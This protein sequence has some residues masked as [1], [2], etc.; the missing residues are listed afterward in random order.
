MPDALLKSPFDGG[1]VNLPAMLVILFISFLL[2]LGIKASSRFNIAM[3]LIKLAVIG[4]FIAI[5]AVNINTTYWQPFMPF[6]W[7]GVMSGAA[8]VFFAYIGFDAVSTTAEEVINPQRN[9]PIGIIVSLVICTLLYIIVSG[10][11]T[12]T[13]PYTHLN[14]ASPIS[15][16]LSH[17]GHNVAASLI[18]IGA[19]SGL[20]T[21]ILVL[22]YALTRVFFAMSRD[23]LLPSFFA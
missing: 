13:V 23:K 15:A 16:A 12:G 8:I 4:L 19:I 10:L 14:V 3:V 17:L 6:G 7:H 22:Y 21:V 20:L 9:L 18:A 2:S 11:L 1:I 5:A